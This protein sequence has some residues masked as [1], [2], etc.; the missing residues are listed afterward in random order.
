MVYL[1]DLFKPIQLTNSIT[2]G[3]AMAKFKKLASPEE[4]CVGRALPFVPLLVEAYSYRYDETPNYG[5][6]R[7]LINCIQIGHKIP[8]LHRFTWGNEGA[9]EQ[10]D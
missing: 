3:E 1:R 6:L 9:P 5:K 4:I 2:T 10:V 7:F 8:P